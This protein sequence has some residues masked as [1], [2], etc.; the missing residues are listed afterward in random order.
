M[1]SRMGWRSWLRSFGV[2]MLLLG[3]PIAPA[4]AE[5]DVAGGAKGDSVFV[6]AVEQ[7]ERDAQLS[8]HQAAVTASSGVFVAYEWVIACSSPGTGTSGSTE[9]DCA[10]A[11]VCADPSARLYRLWGR[12][13]A[14][15]W[16]PLSTQ[17]FGEPPTA[18]D[19]PRPQVTPGLVL[20]EIRRIGLPTLQ[21]RTQP[22]GRTLVNF[23]TIFYTQAQPFTATVT[24]L[25]QQVDIVAEAVE[26]TWHH[27]DGQT[28][29][30]T[31]PG[32]PYPSM[33][34]TY[35]Y[36]DA[37]VTVRPRVDVTY[38]ARFRVNGGAWQ[39]IP[40]TLTIAGP[41][42][43]LRISEARATLSGNYG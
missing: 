26:Y 9:T 2:G 43:S 28:T 11:Q 31:S 13:D 12:T 6:A 17:C 8:S 18:A 10:A 41:E 4:I 19:T 40:E 23:D 33:E 22:E 29:A 38:S 1:T 20:N 21:A 30:T 39:D 15:T 24:L 7:T 27:G 35:R 3:L 37:D 34:I 36:S 25:G 16:L 14:N 42:A 32:A 5:P